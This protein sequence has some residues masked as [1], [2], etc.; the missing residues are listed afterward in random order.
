WKRRRF[1]ARSND[2]ALGGEALLAAGAG[3][4]NFAR[5]SQSR[6]PQVASDLVLAKQAIDTLAENLDDLLLAAEHRGQVQLDAADLHTVLGHLLPGS[7]ELLARFKKR[8]ARNAADSQTRP[9]E[10]RFLLHT[11]RI[12]P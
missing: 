7:R 11:S 1:A 10:A 8:L 3:Q 9:T 6:M 12:Q 2:N 4:R 5:S